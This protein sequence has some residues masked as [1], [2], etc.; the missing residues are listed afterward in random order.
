MFLAPAMLGFL[1]LASAPVIIH[2]LNRRRFVRVDWAPMR[3]LRQTVASNRRRVKL[4]QWL[5]LA[6][7]TLAVAALVLAVARPMLAGS[8]LGMFDVD[9]RSSRVVVVD[10]SLGMG[11]SSD[12]S[13]AWSRAVDA[14]ATLLDRIGPDD[15]VTVL[16]T[17]AAGRPLVTHSRLET[18]DAVV[19]E[20][21]EGRPSDAGSRWSA[22]FEAVDRL[23][24][25]ATYPVKE[26]TLITDLGAYG[27][28]EGVSRAAAEWAGEDVSLRVLDVGRPSPGGLSVQGVRPRD[29]VALVD[30]DTALLVT[31]GNS[32]G[33]VATGE[34]MRV[35]VDGVERSVDLPDVPPGESVTVSVDVAASTAGEHRAEV[36]LPPDALEA[37][38]RAF[39][40]V[41]VRPALD[42]VLVDG[43]P[44]VEPFEG[45]TDFLRLA[46]TAGYSRV[47]V[48]TVLPADWEATP[49]VTADVVV[50]ANVDRVPEGR[51]EE[52]E[53]LVEAGTGLMVFVGSSVSPETLNDQLFAGGEG[54]LPARAGEPMEVDDGAVG[55][56]LGDVAGS[57]LE[58][59]AKVSSRRLA[60][61]KPR[62][63]MPV[64]KPEG[65]EGRVLA[66][67]NDGPQS[68]A[69][70]SG[71]YG[72]GGVLL[73]TV[74]ADRDWSD[75]PTDPT[76]VLAVRAAVMALAGRTGEAAELVAG[77]PLRLPLNI[78]RRPA[79]VTVTP[80]DGEPREMTLVEEDGRL[81]A[82]D[83]DTAA[84]GFQTAEWSEPT[85]G[86]RSRT[87]A[88][89]PDVADAAGGR[90][91]AGELSALLSPLQPEV[92]E[93]SGRVSAEPGSSELWRWAIAAV[94]GLLLCESALAA[95]IDR[96]RSPGVRPT[97]V[98]A[99]GGPA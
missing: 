66:R 50:L 59:L 45:E 4:E 2:L 3:V 57:P 28:D 68:P 61:V 96:R 10:D 84:A 12:G 69:V 39:A 53:R 83:D 89:N 42:V 97:A 56:V 94:I 26:V 93:W 35:T 95:W 51:V 41:N 65:G 43:Q 99:N 15:E 13:T 20:L 88:V 47:N 25:G 90:I 9:G 79:K 60:T 1:A 16:R 24:N 44:G 5:L 63:V 40:V 22:T 49:L 11:E 78:D 36:R 33:E 77:E 81:T 82:V 21:R 18:P 14:A 70:V 76:Y 92:V 17:S 27:W 52:L 98:A 29:P 23:L 85:G 30:V 37:D 91:D 32:S 8:S 7:R 38:G 48:R 58:T 46:L 75:W 62:V 80:T 34:A 67:W 73:W 54:L 86:P 71:S 31:V 74:S 19:A 6:L 72:R 87:F 64:S 55:L